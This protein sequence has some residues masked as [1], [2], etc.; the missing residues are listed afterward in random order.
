MRLAEPLVF[1][2]EDR[3]VTQMPAGS[4]ADGETLTVRV[5]N[6]L[7]YAMPQTGGIGTTPFTLGGLLLVFAAA[8]LLLHHHRKQRREDIASS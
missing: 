4:L 8:I 3:I 2:I 7:A 6:S 1:C 5:Y